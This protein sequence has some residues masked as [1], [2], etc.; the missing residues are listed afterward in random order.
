MLSK[1]E[2]SLNIF[3][4]SLIKI[5]SFEV[6]Y[7]V[8][9]KDSFMILISKTNFENKEEIQFL[10]TRQEIRN[11]VINAVKLTQTKMTVLY[12]N[13]HKSAEFKEKVY[14]KMFKVDTLDYSLSKSFL[15]S[16][17][18]VELFNI[19]QKIKDSIYE[20]ELLFNIKIHSI[21]FIAY[22]KQILENKFNRLIKD[23]SNLIILKKQ[24]Q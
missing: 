12:D 19:I 9:L 11:D 6:L 8:K 2:Y 22:L 18:K 16:I 7:D 23:V 13:K 5:T 15:L 24:K 17:K 20:L 1:I 4:N 3:E 21:I 14:I 10:K